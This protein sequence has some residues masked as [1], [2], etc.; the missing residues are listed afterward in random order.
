VKRSSRHLR[1]NN[2]FN[3]GHWALQTNSSLW[4][5]QSDEFTLE[6]AT[7]FWSSQTTQHGYG[8]TATD[9]MIWLDEREPW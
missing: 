6:F 1:P 3:I 4:L 7:G 9:F 5:L 8:Q 2:Q